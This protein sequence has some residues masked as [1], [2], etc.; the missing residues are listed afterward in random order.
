MEPK[1]FPVVPSNQC[2]IGQDISKDMVKA[3]CESWLVSISY[4]RG[5]QQPEEAAGPK[6]RW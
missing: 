2:D 6:P 4:E 1:G 5:G 3:E